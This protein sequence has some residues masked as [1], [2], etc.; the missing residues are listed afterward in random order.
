MQGTNPSI[1]KTQEKSPNTCNSS[2]CH[3][4]KLWGSPHFTRTFSFDFAAI[5]KTE[6]S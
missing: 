4:I 5:F 3:P 1:S 2:L 6:F